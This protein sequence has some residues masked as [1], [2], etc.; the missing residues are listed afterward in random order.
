MEIEYKN[1]ELKQMACNP[2]NYRGTWSYLVRAFL[3]RINMM[4]Q[5]VDRRDL[6][7]MRSNRLEKLKGN[8]QHQH[9]LWLNDQY[10]LIIQFKQKQGREIISV[11]KI[12][13]YH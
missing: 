11:I 4:K 9:S 7:K 5:A 10:R 3:K 1:P 12:E 6:Y 2:N 13:D 8:R